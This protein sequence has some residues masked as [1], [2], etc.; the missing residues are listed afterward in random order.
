VP[1]LTLG[2]WYH[3]AVTVEGT[4]AGQVKT[5]V[6]GTLVLSSPGNPAITADRFSIGNDA[7]QEWLNGNAAAVKLYSA[8]L[9][10]TEISAEM[11]RLA[12]VRTTNLNGYYPLQAVTSATNDFGGGNRT[13]TQGGTLATDASGPPVQTGFTT[14][15]NTV[16]NGRLW[17]SDPDGNPITFSLQT[18]SANGTVVVNA[19]GTFTYTP[20]AGFTGTTSFVFRV[21]DGSAT[22]TATVSITV[23]P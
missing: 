10:G 16:L 22:A 15:R 19:N 3:F 9:T 2:S 11:N 13:L 18:G 20:T 17:A 6:N 21:S 1:T 23:T 8:V 12:P 5:Y 7:H 14:A 4:G